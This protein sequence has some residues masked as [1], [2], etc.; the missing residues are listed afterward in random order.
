MRGN[1]LGGT[2]AAAGRASR[3]G[4]GVKDKESIKPKTDKERLW[5]KPGGYSS[6]VWPQ[7]VSKEQP[8]PHDR[9]P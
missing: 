4:K 3:V 5:H 8:G 2:V 9:G 7:C 1:K 6:S